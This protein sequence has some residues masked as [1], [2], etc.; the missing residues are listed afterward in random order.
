MSST[1][2]DLV[3]SPLSSPQICSRFSQWPTS[4][5]P[6]LPRLKGALAIPVDPRNRLPM[7]TPSRR[8]RST[9]KLSV[10]QQPAAQIAGPKVEVRV[11]RP[12]DLPNPSNLIISSSF[13]VASRSPSLYGNSAIEVRVRVTPV[14]VF[15]RGSRTASA[16]SIMVSTASAR[17]GAGIVIAILVLHTV[18]PVE[19]G[20]LTVDLLLSEICLPRRRYA[21]HALRQGYG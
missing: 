18:V 14:V 8:R 11:P 21:A 9:G 4:C 7:T 2:S 16:N 3:Q 1:A 5:T 13:L 17:N 15:P 12:A 20:D 6:V 10:S 19:R